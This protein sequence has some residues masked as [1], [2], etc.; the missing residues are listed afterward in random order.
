MTKLYF[1]G[2]FYKILG[3]FQDKKHFFSNSMNFVLYVNFSVKC[4]KIA[5]KWSPSYLTK[6]KFKD[7]SRSG[8]SCT[9]AYLL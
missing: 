3:Q 5:P 7:F 8:E 2:L 4:L 6:V 1:Q 9:K